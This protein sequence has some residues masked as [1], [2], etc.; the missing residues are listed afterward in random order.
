MAAVKAEAKYA[1]I[2]EDEEGAQAT[3]AVAVAIKKETDDE[4]P[5]LTSDAHDVKGNMR[6]LEVE[7]QAWKQGERQQPAFRDKWFVVVF[8]LH[9][10]AI[11]TTAITLGSNMFSNSAVDD[12]S[13]NGNS[14]EPK[15]DA[16]A[17]VGMFGAII[18]ISTLLS[19]ILSIVAL[20]IMSKNA[21][22]LLEFSLIFAVGLNL[23]LMIVALLTGL[24]FNV[25]LHGLFAVILA[26]YA[27][28]TWHRIPYA[29]ANL[30]AAIAAVQL[31]LGVML[32]A[33]SSMVVF[34][35]WI[36]TWGIAFGG[37][38]LQPDL[39]TTKATQ[40]RCSDDGTCI[41]PGDI[42]ITALGFFL[43]ICFLLSFYW[44]HQVIQ[45]VV[46]STVAGTVGTWWFSPLE[47]SSFCSRGVS[48]SLVR[49][50]TYSLGSICFGSLIVAVLQVMRSM[51]RGVANNRRSGILRCVAECILLYIERLVEYFN[52]WA[53]I[54]V[55]LYGYSYVE[56]AK[57]VIELFRARGFS[58]IISDNLVNRLLGIVILL[59]GLLAGV[60]SV[61]ISLTF[62]VADKASGWLAPSFFTGF[63]IGIVLSGIIMGVVSSAV[64]T[65]IVCYAE[66]PRELDA[67]HPE[68]SQEF[69]STWQ[70]AWPDLNIRG[71]AVVSLGGG[72]GIV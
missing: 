36:L 33:L 26:V 3:T 45:N 42:E 1:A 19:P 6:Q 54:Y 38:I 18:V 32:V 59:I 14:E 8:L 62:E 47:A 31:N 24:F 20:G 25:L 51:L 50:T 63:F 16:D 66:A 34:V 67:N 64:D 21:V 40:E 35:V 2:P 60:A 52:K 41:E 55:G 30:K 48:D 58:A 22:K 15:N 11:I 13:L 49:S 7:G 4:T 44:T 5:S 69:E 57:A 29:A 46:R 53:F 56:A 27:R 65:I 43:Y 17:P 28:S 71:I 12:S 72:L 61:L 10:M 70:T 9:L 39:M 23:I 68:I 37:A